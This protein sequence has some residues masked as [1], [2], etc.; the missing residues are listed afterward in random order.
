MRQETVYAFSKHA[1]QR[2]KERKIKKEWVLLVLREGRMWRHGET[3]CYQLKV[4]SIL[5]LLYD[6][7]LLKQ[8]IVIVKQQKIVTAYF[9][10]SLNY[11]NYSLLQMNKKT[12]FRL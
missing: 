2:L 10:G 11:K 5:P 6:E 9:S 8:L 4:E 12:K 3:T 7:P 1:K